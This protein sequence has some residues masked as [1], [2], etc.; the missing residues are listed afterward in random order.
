MLTKSILFADDE[1]LPRLWFQRYFRQAGYQAYVAASRSLALA[2][3]QASRPAILVTDLRL[4]ADSGI[5]LVREVKEH[6]PS[7]RVVLLSGWVTVAATAFAMR[8]GCELVLAK[9]VLP[10]E[11][12]E[13]LERG[14]QDLGTECRE[15]PPTLARATFEHAL[16][17][18]TDVRGNTSEAARRLGVHRQTLQRLLRKAP[19]R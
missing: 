7:T 1:R 2:E 9:P 5:D 11:L 14:D 8:A 19:H 16:R 12:L 18:F 3:L 4:G 10:G 13:R 15:A 6:A 17:V